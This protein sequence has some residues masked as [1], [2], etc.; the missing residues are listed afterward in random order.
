M[1]NKI[2]KILKYI[3]EKHLSKIVNISLGFFKYTDSIRELEEICNELVKNGIYIVAAEPQERVY[4]GSFKSVIGV[5]TDKSIESLM[6]TCLN[7]HIRITV[8]HEVKTLWWR[9]NY[10]I[11]DYG[12]SFATAEMTGMLAGCLYNTK[13]EDRSIEGIWGTIK[14]N[15]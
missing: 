4:P 8:K 1:P 3:Q 5:S 6:L 11:E 15:L 12:A 7:G 14:N 10:V 13:C 2:S 9:H